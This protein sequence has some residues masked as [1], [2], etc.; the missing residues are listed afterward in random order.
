MMRTYFAWISKRYGVVNPAQDLERPKKQRPARKRLTEDD[1]YRLM[2]ACASDRDRLVVFI[3]AMT[4][5]RKSDLRNLHWRDV[6]LRERLLVVQ[7]GKGRKGREVPLP[8]P[9]V[10]LLAD[11]AGRLQ[12]RGAFH[13]DYFVCPKTIDH[14][15]PQGSRAHRV[16][17]DKQ[18]GVAAAY[19]VLHRLALSGGVA[20][21]CSPHDLRRYY[22]GQFLKSNPG[23][24]FRLQ[25]V[26][27]HAEISTTRMYLP[28]ADMPHVR[29]AVDRMQWTVPADPAEM[30]E[31]VE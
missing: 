7:L 18:M 10:Q 25:A 23:D 30:P 8:P 31:V 12:E 21:P 3:L 9:L 6:N 14:E 11:V 13:P 28:A 22:A 16:E 29:E 1:V 26:L 20:L 4:G 15:M 24:L 19:K 27:G 17:H 2:R 5:I